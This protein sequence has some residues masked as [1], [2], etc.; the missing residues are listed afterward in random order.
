MP[1]PP[2]SLASSKDCP[3]TR[4]QFASASSMSRQIGL[5]LSG[6]IATGAESGSVP[7]RLR[8]RGPPGRDSDQRAR[9][10]Q[11]FRYLLQQGGDCR[12]CSGR[13]ASS[14]KLVVVDKS[15]TDGTLEVARR[16]A[17]K[18]VV[19]PWTPTADDTRSYAVE[20]CSHDMIV[21][22]DDDECLSPEAIKFILDESANPSAE[23]YRL[24]FR[25]YFLG[26]FDKR[27]RDWPEYH[28]RLFRRGALEFSPTIHSNTMVKSSKVLTIPAEFADFRA[29]PFLRQ[30]RSMAREGH[31]IYVSAGKSRLVPQIHSPLGRIWCEGRQTIG[32]AIRKPRAMIMSRLTPSCASS[33]ISS[34]GSNN[35]RRRPG[36]MATRPSPKYASDCRPNMTSS[37]SRLAGAG[38]PTAGTGRRLNRPLSPGK[39]REKYMLDQ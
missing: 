6:T 26:R 4:S 31:A 11:R 24:P 32:L 35:G 18:V 20:L 2:I 14:M 29:S 16:Y 25:S 30:R 10:D 21:Y 19:V 7:S 23:V 39:A 37:S 22:L 8:R 1:V 34:I 38:S 12:T 27:R 15:S 9:K 5:A 36:S 13:S 33:T 28:E 3:A 17:D